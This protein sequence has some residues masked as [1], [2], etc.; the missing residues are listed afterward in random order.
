ML[1]AIYLVIGPIIESPQIEL[2]YAFL[3]IIGGLLFYFPFV[4]FKLKIKGFG[5]IPFDV[6]LYQKLYSVY[7][8]G[9]NC[10]LIYVS[11][12][13]EH[14][15]L[16]CYIEFHH[17]NKNILVYWIRTITRGLFFNCV[18]DVSHYPRFD[19]SHVVKK[20][21]KDLKLKVLWQVWCSEQYFF[22][23]IIWMFLSFQNG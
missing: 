14:L 22:I 9:F 5:K 3:F 12:Y 10:L 19:F 6:T 21:F 2:L 1:I 8:R 11:I 15:I 13:H 4:Y 23:T 17:R 16:I 18:K 20:K 7:L